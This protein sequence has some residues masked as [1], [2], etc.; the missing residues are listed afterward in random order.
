MLAKGVVQI[1]VTPKTRNPFSIKALWISGVTW[2]WH[3]LNHALDLH[4]HVLGV[5]AAKLNVR[6]VAER[7]GDIAQN[8]NFAVKGDRAAAFLRA[9]GVNLATAKSRGAERSVAD[10]CDSAN[11]STVLIRCER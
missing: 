9:A 6:T 10:V 4:G 3:V 11:R 8:V 7:T 1:R 2:N 5:V